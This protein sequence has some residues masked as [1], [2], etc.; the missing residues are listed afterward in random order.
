M[1][2]SRVCILEAYICL[3]IGHLPF[4]PDMV[5]QLE[6][7]ENLWVMEGETQRNG[8]SS[9]DHV[10]VPSGVSWSASHHV[11]HYHS[12]L[13]TVLSFLDWDSSLHIGLP[14]SCLAPL[15]SVLHV[16]PE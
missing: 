1:Y 12:C 10:A 16:V 3:F 2:F 5:S 8:Y 9:E 6:A 13:S 7:E 14:A 11:C 4:K 15:S